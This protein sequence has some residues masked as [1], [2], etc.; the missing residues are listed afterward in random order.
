MT[1]CTRTGE[2]SIPCR[3]IGRIVHE[4]LA[5]LKIRHAVANNIPP[6]NSMVAA[7][8]LCQSGSFIC[9]NKKS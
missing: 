6:P 9:L 2:N 4:A 3:T 8:L 7:V 1:T 5:G